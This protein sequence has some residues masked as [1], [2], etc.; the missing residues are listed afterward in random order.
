MDSRRQLVRTVI[1]ASSSSD[2]DA[3]EDARGEALGLGSAKY[4]AFLSMVNHSGLDT[5]VE[6]PVV[7]KG[8]EVLTIIYE[9]M[10]RMGGDST[11]HALYGKLLRA[12]GAPYVGMIKTWTTTG[13]LV[14]PHD[15]FLV[16]EHISAHRGTLNNGGLGEYWEETYTLRDGS[17]VL[18]VQKAGIPPPRSGS[19][20][21][22]GG[23]CIPPPLEQWKHKILLAGKYVNITRECG[24]ELGHDETLSDKENLS[25]ND[26]QLYKFIESAYRHAN[27]TLLQLLTENQSLIRQLRT[28]KKHLLL[29]DSTYINHFLDLSYFDLR[30]SSHTVSVRKLQSLLDIALYADTS[31]SREEL[32]DTNARVLG[33]D[34]KVTMAD[35][36]L[37]E[38]LLKV[39]SV[40]SLVV[41][42][43]PGPSEGARQKE[44][45]REKEGDDKRPLLAIDALTLDFSIKFPHSLVISRECILRY[46]LLF[47]FLLQ[48]KH[49]ERSL[50]SMW[51]EHKSTLWRQTLPNQSELERWRLRISLL[52]TRMSAFVQHILAF[53]TFEVIEPNWRTLE[54][55]LANATT[56]DQL[57]IFHADFL[58]TCLKGC[59]LTSSKLLEAQSRLINTCSTFALY[60]SAFSKHIIKALAA[61]ATPQ[62]DQGMDERWNFLAK[63]EAHFN[64][65][66]K[67]FLNY[68]QLDA[69][70]ENASLLPLIGQLKTVQPEHD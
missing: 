3:D 8:G 6:S 30:K 53:A 51:I 5:G 20:R 38:W 9:R 52:R 2:S 4:K 68:I 57:S 27:R 58:D 17:T 32:D 16:K 45:E 54:M 48:M 10:Q 42:K 29:A 28:I 55:K 61:A 40:N 14:D 26:E 66:F 70:S 36:G 56:V 50:S 21:L 13:R 22:P 47:R 19:G 62:G 31:G 44:K 64:H 18:N 41:A 33:G 43:V 59:M 39:V 15:E 60:A 63:F 69:L 37:Y 65:W 1:G 24:I 11:A 25:L 34:L 49:V 12:A 7:V 23:A 46:Q 67:L 35:S